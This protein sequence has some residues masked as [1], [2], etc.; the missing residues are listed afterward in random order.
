MLGRQITPS[1][2]LRLFD[3]FMKI[4]GFVGSAMPSRG[5]A[6]HDHAPLRI[7]HGQTLRR[8]TERRCV[9][10][11]VRRGPGDAALVK[12]RARHPSRAERL[13]E[14]FF[15]KLLKEQ[16]SIAVTE[17]ARDAIATP[18]HHRAHGIDKVGLSASS[19]LMH[20]SSPSR[21]SPTRRDWEHRHPLHETGDAILVERRAEHTTMSERAAKRRHGKLQSSTVPT[22][23]LD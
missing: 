6:G 18:I 13:R 3:V 4:T 12:R 23:P 14:R 15:G 8:Y 2:Q 9:N 21:P 22:F 5:P 1:W 20:P 11:F 7:L 17:R 10:G 16:S 19:H